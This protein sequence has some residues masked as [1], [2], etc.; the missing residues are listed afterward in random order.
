MAVNELFD[1]LVRV[2]LN[3][4]LALASKAVGLKR[5]RRTDNSQRLLRVLAETDKA[6]TSGAI[7]E[8]LDIKPASVTGLVGKL[9]KAGYV[10]RV[11]DEKDAR[12]VRIKITE[13]G[14][15]FLESK[16]DVVDQFKAAL[17]VPL[18]ESEREQLES[19]LD[20][21]NVYLE[22]DEFVDSIADILNVPNFAKKRFT[23]GAQ[24]QK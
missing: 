22:S 20:K 14:K 2:A 17:F 10:V 24:R 6:M 9:E 19:L 23:K 8:I 3:P 1:E 12:V 18:D 11:K 21:L 15:D 7:A 4:S 13:P 5:T 16:T